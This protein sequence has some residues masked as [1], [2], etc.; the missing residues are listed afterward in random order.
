MSQKVA[1]V[2]GAAGP[3][4]TAIA[5][6]L[7]ASRR[8]VVMVD[9]NEAVVDVAR[10]MNDKN[11]HAVVADLGNEAELTRLGAET[12]ANHGSIDILIN[13]AGIHPKNNGTK[14]LL[15]EISLSQWQDVLHINLTV[16]FL[17][18][19]L[20]LP[21]MKAKG[22]GRIVNVSSRGGRAV[23]P[24]AAGHYSA[25]K[26]GLIG[27][28]RT[29]AYETASFGITANSVAPGPIGKGMAETSNDAMVDVRRD[30]PVNRRGEPADVAEAVGYLASEEAGFVTGAIIDVAG[31]AFMP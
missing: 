22:W 31:G 16:P 17:L 23:S 7:L 29:M 20:V 24:L 6:R 3:I 11:A 19:K 30:A 5:K 12:K 14:F 1:L 21:F 2:T 27:L 18:Y 26:A 15:D 4:G 13:N 8:I 10:S 9:R 28:T 25:S